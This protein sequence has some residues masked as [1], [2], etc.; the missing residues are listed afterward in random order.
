MSGHQ[1][2]SFVGPDGA[3]IPLASA[4][5]SARLAPATQ[6]SVRSGYTALLDRSRPKF[7]GRKPRPSAPCSTSISTAVRCVWAGGVGGLL[8]SLDGGPDRR[9]DGFWCLVGCHAADHVADLA[10]LAGDQ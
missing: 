3:A 5:P 8:R 2:A 6:E 9:V 4:A 1:R 10:D 7:V